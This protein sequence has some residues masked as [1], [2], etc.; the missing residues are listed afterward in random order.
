[1]EKG[2]YNRVAFSIV[3]FL[4]ASY[5]ILEADARK[6]PGKCSSD[7]DCKGACESQCTLCSWN[8]SAQECVCSSFQQPKDTAQIMIGMGVGPLMAEISL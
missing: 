2:S 7:P 8:F 3:I 1:M 6:V 4:M 5:F